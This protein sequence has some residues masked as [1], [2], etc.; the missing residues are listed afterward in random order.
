[1]SRVDINTNDKEIQV[2]LN[3]PPATEEDFSKM[4]PIPFS[5]VKIGDY[6]AVNCIIGKIYVRSEPRYAYVS[7]ITEKGNLVTIN[8][9]YPIDGVIRISYAISIGNNSQPADEVLGI[10]I[11]D[12]HPQY[13]I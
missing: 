1:M 9:S 5:D 10:F 7:D 2:L 11:P 8:Y 6:I 3:F 4:T 12:T 13:F